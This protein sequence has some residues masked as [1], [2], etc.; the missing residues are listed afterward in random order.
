[1]AVFIQYQLRPPLTLSAWG[2]GTISV[3]P[4]RSLDVKAALTAGSGT[5]AADSTDSRLIYALDIYPPLQRTGTTGVGTPVP[6]TGLLAATLTSPANSEVIAFNAT[7]GRWENA[8]GGT[9][10]GGGGLTA[11]VQETSLSTALQAKIDNAVQPPIAITTLD[12]ATQALIN[13]ATQAPVNESDL[14]GPLATKINSRI[15]SGRVVTLGNLGATQTVT[16]TVADDQGQVDVFCTLNADGV[17]V[18]DGVQTVTRC[19]IR[20]VVTQDAT[21]NHTFAIKN[22]FSGTQVQINLDLVPA[23]ATFCYCY[24]DDGSTLNVVGPDTSTAGG[25]T[26]G[27]ISNPTFTGAVAVGNVL[28]ATAPPELLPSSIAWQWQSSTDGIAWTDLVG[29][30][31]TT[32]AYTVQSADTSKQLTVRVSGTPY[33][34]AQS[35]LVPSPNISFVETAQQTTATSTSLHVVKPTTAA[36]GDVL[37]AVIT[38]TIGTTATIPTPPTGWTQ[39]SRTANSGGPIIQWVFWYR[40]TSGDSATTGWNF[41]SDTSETYRSRCTAFRNVISTGTPYELATAA[42]G[43]FNTTVTAPSKTPTGTGRMYVVMVSFGASQGITWPASTFTDPSG[44]D[45]GKFGYMFLG[46]STAATGA[47]NG[48]VVSGSQ[49]KTVASLL[50]LPGP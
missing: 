20:V 33:A 11:P 45:Y 22:N 44:N 7:T 5:I 30:G 37:L 24:T 35:V 4:D 18:I 41:T 29:N 32:N 25:G 13:G 23:A 26:G 50:L 9:G 49:N 43:T 1:M 47:I 19:T 17:L 27:G 34:R 39:I 15:P 2:G 12:T 3:G 46:A 6:L 42:N 36:A 21:G 40:L 16:L 48:T 14:D 10:G 8:P 28:T 38:G 31:A